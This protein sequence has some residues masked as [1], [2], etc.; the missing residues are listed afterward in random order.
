MLG[1]MMR[2]I[3]DATDDRTMSGTSLTIRSL[4]VLR[5]GATNGSGATN[6]AGSASGARGAAT[7][8]R[9]RGVGVAARRIA[10]VIRLD[11]D[12]ADIRQQDGAD[13]HEQV[14]ERPVE[15]L[16]ERCRGASA[17]I[18]PSKRVMQDTPDLRRVLCAGDGFADG[19]LHRHIENINQ[20]LSLAVGLMG[21]RIKSAM[22]LVPSG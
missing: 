1:M 19:V 6:G 4:P 14:A 15:F 18:R 5:W 22:S 13:Q 21:L 3:C 16:A 7:G 11:V 9:R 8:R 10:V 20:Y 17:T 2:E 12:A